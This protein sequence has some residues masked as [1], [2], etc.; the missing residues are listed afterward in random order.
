MIRICVQLLRSLRT[1]LVFWAVVSL[2]FAGGNF[3]HAELF[4]PDGPTQNAVNHHQAEAETAHH[5]RA[6]YS[7][8]HH[9]NDTADNGEI[10]CG[11]TLLAL[12]GHTASLSGDLRA[13]PAENLVASPRANRFTADPPPPK[14]VV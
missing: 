9:N 12:T 8:H 3:A 1:G 5:H 11:A 4:T 14:S 10:H 7:G 6:K 2:L 13:V